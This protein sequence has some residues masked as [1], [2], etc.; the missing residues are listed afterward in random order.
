MLQFYSD[1]LICSAFGS[2]GELFACVS[3]KRG[4]DADRG[5]DVSK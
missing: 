3:D 1:G 4:D 2:G 5:N